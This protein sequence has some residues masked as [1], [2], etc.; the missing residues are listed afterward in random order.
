MKKWLVAAAVAALAAGAG[1]ETSEPQK[2]DA[3]QASAQ[4]ATQAEK[5]QEQDKAQQETAEE[6]EAD[7]S[8][9]EEGAKKTQDGLAADLPAGETGTYGAEFTIEGEPMTLAAAMQ[10]AAEGEGPYKVSANIEKV[11]KKKGCWFTLTAEGVDQPVR[12][13]MKDYGFFVPRNSAG[14]EAIV[15]G[16]LIKRV[17]PQ[18]EA[19][20]YADDEVA[21]T[22][23]EPKKIEGDQVRW[24]MLITAAKIT[25][26]S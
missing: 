8:A 25:N 1:C 11:C 2:D 14:G 22:D 12:V 7:D 6:A 26:K 5:S 16:K 20:H 3:S 15:E 18:K 9:A 17:V 23:K 4:E 19:Q 10:K 13:K 24:E 21:G